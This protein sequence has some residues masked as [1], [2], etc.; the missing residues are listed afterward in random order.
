MAGIGNA[1]MYRVA[2]IVGSLRAGSYNRALF[3]AAVSAVPSRLQIVEAPILDVP[4]FNQDVEDAGD[5]E[6]VAG[7]RQAI[8]GA[9]GV[10]I[11]CPEYNAGIPGVL[12]NALDWASRMHNGQRVLWDK[13]VGIMGASDG[14]FGTTRS[15]MAM[16]S[17]LPQLGMRLMPTPAVMIAQV[18]EL[19]DDDGNLS[20]EKTR[21]RI[22]EHL[23]AF[24][25][26]IDVFARA[27]RDREP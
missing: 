18:E 15:Q 14:R 16:R 23:E 19:V 10:L 22:R 7:L 2:G 20:D 13:P 17:L 8:S 6:A 26:W 12:K 5:P 4:L 25:H 21:E 27:E 1:T 11:F 3:R 9:D 24:H